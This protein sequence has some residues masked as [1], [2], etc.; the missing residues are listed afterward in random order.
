M[1]E[2]VEKVEK[3]QSATITQS[4]GDGDDSIVITSASPITGL[5][6]GE[7]L[8]IDNYEVVV[9]EV[10]NNE[11]TA[12]EN[13]IITLGSK[14][15]QFD[16]TIP[17][18][19]QFSSN[20]F[21]GV[22]KELTQKLGLKLKFKMS[23]KHKLPSQK[24]AIT[25]KQNVRS[26]INDIAS[27][28]TQKAVVW[29]V[30]LYGVFWAVD[31]GYE[32]FS[33]DLTPADCASKSTSL[34]MEYRNKEKLVLDNSSKPAV[35][36]GDAIVYSVRK[37]DEKVVFAER[38][39]KVKPRTTEQVGEVPQETKK[40]AYWVTNTNIFIPHLVEPAIF[41]IVNL[42]DFKSGNGKYKVKNITHSY[43]SSGIISTNILLVSEEIVK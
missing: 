17:G 26:Y 41:D 34:S 16:T 12:G 13:S 43:K 42:K 38:I 31:V 24:S 9:R 5:F 14:Q 20:T 29:W 39:G 35:E 6:P 30:D 11:T 19:M 36:P 18:G 23:T 1:F 33:F 25:G 27:I 22:I 15:I 2:F 10:I 40:T 8:K 37:G 3:I 4:G 21:E 32:G 28:K 7:I